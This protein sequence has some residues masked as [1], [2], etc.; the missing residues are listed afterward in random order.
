M[1]G[2]VE[3]AIL[4]FQ[5]ILPK[6]HHYAPS[7]YAPPNYGAKQQMAKIDTTPSMTPTQIKLLKNV[8]GKFLYITN[9]LEDTM[10]LAVDELATSKS[11]GTQETVAGIPYFFDYGA[12]NPNPVKRQQHDPPH[13]Q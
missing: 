2:Y 3:K 6:E 7:R 12:C 4:Q 8:T 11:G 10:L 1:N 9:A 13:S 5:H